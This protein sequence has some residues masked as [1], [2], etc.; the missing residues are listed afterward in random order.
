MSVTV[1][2]SGLLTSVQGNVRNGWRHLGVGG[3]GAVDGF[4]LSIANLLVGNAAQ[5]AAIEITLTGPRLHFAHAARIAICGAQIDASLEEDSLPNWRRIDIPANSEVRLGVCRRGARAYLAVAGGFQVKYVLGSPSTDLRAGFGGVEGRA[6]KAGDTLAIAEGFRP[7]CDRVVIDPRWIDPA[8]D[9]DFVT[10]SVIHL[11]ASGDPMIDGEALFAHEWKVGSASNRQGL[12]LEGAKLEIADKRERISEPV[13]PGTLQLPAD[14]QPIL[15]LADAQTHGGYPR[16]GHAI[17]AD[18]P[19]LAQ[20][21]AGDSLRFVPCDARQ[22]QQKLIEQRQRL[23][24][25]A[26]AI[27]STA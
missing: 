1:L 23:T 9:L 15:L 25:M 27:S 4:S 17:R 13:F 14:G 7:Q 21:R 24:R 12:R 16:I 5:A 10:P 6:L 3:S 18:W 22:A 11:L 8:P 19:R 20:L 2:S 26:I